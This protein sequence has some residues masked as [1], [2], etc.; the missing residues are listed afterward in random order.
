METK[1]KV[2]ISLVATSICLCLTLTVVAVWVFGRKTPVVAQ[3]L[4]SENVQPTTPEF[5]PITVEK[6]ISAQVISDGLRE[7]GRLVT[8]EYYFTDVLSYSS[9]LKFLGTFNVPFTTSGFLVSY[10][11]VVTAGVDFEKIEVVK[12]EDAKRITVHLP[13][14]EIMNVDIDPES[15]VLH[16]EKTGLGNPISISDFN[17]SLA[18]LESSARE[19]AVEKGL[20]G[21][22]GE[23]AEKVI[24]HFVDSLLESGTY[25]VRY[26]HQG[27]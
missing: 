12:D 3:T 20:L 10:D 9:A 24:S 6:A 2:S 17:Q 1:K 16:A 7:L 11:G 4:A 22:A 23:N 14:P 13:A 27:G 8:E 19:K 15:F 18:E 25:T 26:V 21:R 5:R